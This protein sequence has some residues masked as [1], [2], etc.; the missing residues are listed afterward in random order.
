MAILFFNEDIKFNLSQKKLLKNWI[1][2]AISN[3]NKKC[4]SINFIL[5]SDNFLLEINKKFLSHNYFTDIVTFNY[6]T[7][8]LISGDIYI[9]VETVKNNSIRFNVPMI[10]ELYRV[11]IHGVLHLIG[12][13]DSNDL[14]KSIMREKEDFYLDRLKKLS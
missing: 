7:N 12:Y 2:Q 4:D 3:E 11:M 6:C 1:K 13:N 5:T 10:E 14:E 8:S 9:S